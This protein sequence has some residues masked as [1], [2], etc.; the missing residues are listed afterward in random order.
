MFSDLLHRVGR[1]LPS[2]TPSAFGPRQR[3]QSAEGSWANAEEKDKN[4]TARLI[5]CPF[6]KLP[7]PEQLSLELIPHLDEPRLSLRRD[8]TTEV[9]EDF[10]SSSTRLVEKLDA[11]GGRA[12]HVA[13]LFHGEY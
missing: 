8:H 4:N 5:A 10:K 3:G 12:V 7:P 1:L 2:A 13:G 11:A 9:K 6:T